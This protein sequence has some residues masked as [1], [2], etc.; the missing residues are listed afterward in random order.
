MK[1]VLE[2]K[3]ENRTDEKIQEFKAL[4]H[5]RLSSQ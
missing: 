1:N 3:A 4:Q 2:R 5:S